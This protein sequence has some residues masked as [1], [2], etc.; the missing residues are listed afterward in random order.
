MR[1]ACLQDFAILLAILPRPTCCERMGGRQLLNGSNQ[2]AKVLCL[3]QEASTQG[4]L[5]KNLTH[6]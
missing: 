4:A 1:C 3:L 5:H 6:T 2:N